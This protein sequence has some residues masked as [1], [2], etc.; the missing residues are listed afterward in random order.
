MTLQVQM[1]RDTGNGAQQTASGRY[2]LTSV[3]LTNRHLRLERVAGQDAARPLG[4]YF[5]KDIPASLKAEEVPELARGQLDH[6]QA[7]GK[8]K[9]ASSGQHHSGKEMKPLGYY[10]TRDIPDALK[11]QQQ[12]AGRG[13]SQSM[14]PEGAIAHISRLESE[15]AHAANTRLRASYS[16][17]DGGGGDRKAKPLG[18]YFASD[19]PAD[20][21]AAAEHEGVAVGADVAAQHASRVDA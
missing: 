3:R 6:L 1:R 13:R 15:R 9:A 8:E 18:Y 19:I 17:A 12:Q 2:Q 16:N 10:F 11:H 20:V 7:L 4:Y 21:K 14:L 5:A